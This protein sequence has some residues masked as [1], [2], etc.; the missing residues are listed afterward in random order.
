MRYGTT[1]SAERLLRL[2]V[3]RYPGNPEHLSPA[4]SSGVRNSGPTQDHQSWPGVAACTG[5][6][7]RCTNSEAADRAE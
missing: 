7:C 3:P 4:R 2:V 5:G 1:R 6:A